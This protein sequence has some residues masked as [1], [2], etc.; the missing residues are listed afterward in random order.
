M[1]NNKVVLSTGEVLIDLT[2]DT[3]ETG[4]VLSGYT[5]HDK[6]GA[7]VAGT[8]EYDADSSD[9]TAIAAHLKSGE[10]AYARGQKI[11]GTAETV[12]NAETEELTVPDWMVTING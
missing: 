7:S 5:F 6:T 1:A 2:A 3:A 4:H 11:T 9:A 10:T 8:C 12:Y